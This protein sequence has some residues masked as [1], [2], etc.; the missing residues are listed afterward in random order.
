[1][2]M[3]SGR[4]R[5]LAAGGAR[6]LPLVLPLVLLAAT[7]AVAGDGLDLNARA[8]LRQQ[9]Q[10]RRGALPESPASQ[11][12]AVGLLRGKLASGPATIQTQIRPEW[13]HDLGGRHDGVSGRIHLD[14]GY[15]RLAAN[16]AL[17]IELGKRQIV[18]G[19]GLGFNPTDYWSEGKVIDRTVDDETRRTEREGD[20]VTGFSY[21]AEGGSIQGYVAPRLD[22]PLQ[23]E[24]TR[25]SLTLTRAFVDLD[26]DAAL[27]LYGGDRPAV[28]VNL[29]VTMTEALVAYTETS[30]RR[31]RDRA[32][33]ETT[34]SSSTYAIDTDDER[35][36]VDALGGFQYTFDNGVN[37]A[38]EYFHNGEG[39]SGGEIDR[40][41][42]LRTEPLPRGSGA[43]ALGAL[44]ARTRD[45]LS[46]RNLRRDY[47]FVRVN[48]IKVAGSTT[49]ELTTIRNLD[50]QGQFFRALAN[51]PLTDRDL[52]Q[53]YG[54]LFQGPTRSEYGMN[55]VEER[56]LFLYRHHF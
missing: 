18:Q 14:E 48:N 33:V 34:S 6:V 1:M 43:A 9:F 10:D 55:G 37:L 28:G 50:D 29:S 5:R 11:Q 8:D 15:L 22:H 39:Y 41:F 16:D 4:I 52:L 53:V 47:A 12:R 32:A 21:Y 13:S 19:V 40:I 26:A 31:G 54:S 44:Q 27:T 36:F 17:F 20:V 24:P 49:L 45:L 23:S 42:A 7:P 51:V 38:T 56:L 46:S 30:F 25:Y 2:E 35:L 3:V